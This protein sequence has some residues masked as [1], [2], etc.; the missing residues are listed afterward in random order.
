MVEDI[1]KALA[2]YS[3]PTKAEHS[4]RFFRTGPGEYG[5]GDKFLGIVVPDQRKV[6]KQ[7]YQEISIADTVKLLSSEYHEHRLTAAFVLVYKYEKANKAKTNDPKLAKKIYDT[8]LKN[9]RFI[10]NWDLVDT[11]TP[12]IIGHFLLHHNG[13]RKILYQ[14]AKSKDLWERRIAIMATYTFIKAKQFTDTIAIA[15]ILVNDDHD[16][17]HKAVGWMLREVGKLDLA[18]EE[19]FL[20]QHYKTMPRTMLRYAIEKFPPKKKDFYMGR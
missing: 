5:A 14:Y 7:F 15:G 6:A 4:A 19:K 3:N 17:I 10:N 13:D 12:N 18:A 20:K 9:R 2:K 11:S 16:L 1:K 8:Y